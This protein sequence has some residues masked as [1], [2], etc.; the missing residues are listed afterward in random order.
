M[1]PLFSF[2][3]SIINSQFFLSVLTFGDGFSQLVSRPSWHR[4]IYYLCPTRRSS[5]KSVSI[6]ICSQSCL[7]TNFSASEKSCI[8]MV[9][10]IFD[11]AN[12]TKFFGFFYGQFSLGIFKSFD[13]SH[14]CSLSL[15]L[16]FFFGYPLFVG[17]ACHNALRMNN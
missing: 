17:S 4:C 1:F 7:S 9:F 13:S 10:W 6:R 15:L 11:Y 3:F 2:Q 8:I 14:P 12:D 5:D 16:R